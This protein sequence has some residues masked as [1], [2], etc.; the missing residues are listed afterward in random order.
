MQ[1]AKRWI[2]EKGKQIFNNHRYCCIW[3]KNGGSWS[4]WSCIIRFEVSDLWE[5]LVL[6]IRLKCHQYCICIQLEAALY[7]FWWNYTAERFQTAHSGYHDQIIKS[8]R[9]QCWI[10]SEKVS[11]SGW[12]S[13]IW[14]IRSLSHQLLSFEMCC[15]WEKLQKFKGKMQTKLI[16]QNMFP[17]FPWKVTIRWHYHHNMYYINYLKMFCNCCHINNQC[18][19]SICNVFLNFHPQIIERNLS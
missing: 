7:R 6:A 8:T 19:L 11:Q 1:N 5:K 12:W 3:S 10:S 9:H 16:C 4:T 13:G 14:W 18:I 2:K 17:D 15:L